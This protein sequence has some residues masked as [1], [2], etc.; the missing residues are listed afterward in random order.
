MFK[1]QQLVLSAS[2]TVKANKYNQAK[3]HVRGPGVPCL[4]GKNFRVRDF[5]FIKFLISMVTRVDNLGAANVL[6]FG[7]GNR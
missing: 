1:T 3:S 6:L 2:V 4:V 7:N 5:H